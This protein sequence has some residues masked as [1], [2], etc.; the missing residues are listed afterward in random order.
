MIDFLTNIHHRKTAVD[1]YIE[2]VRRSDRYTIA[3]KVVR[4][5]N[6]NKIVRIMAKE[7]L[8]KAIRKSKE[9]NDEWFEKTAAATQPHTATP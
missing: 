8:N 9:E 3:E 5:Y 1:V 4:I 2:L 7:G 6:A